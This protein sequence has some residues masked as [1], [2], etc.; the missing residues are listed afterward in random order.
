MFPEMLLFERFKRSNVKGSHADEERGVGT[1][2][3]KR[4]G[5]GVGG[6]GHEKRDSHIRIKKSEIE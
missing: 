3:G 5:E 1:G 6:R 4:V 2:S